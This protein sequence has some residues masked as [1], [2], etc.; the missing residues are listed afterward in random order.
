MGVRRDELKAA[1][2]WQ[3]SKC[4][5]IADQMDKLQ[6]KAEMWDVHCGCKYSAEDCQDSQQHFNRKITTNI[7]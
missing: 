1:A 4:V 6:W 2:G 3:W 5:P 7:P